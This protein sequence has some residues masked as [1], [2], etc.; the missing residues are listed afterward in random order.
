M[1][2]I[3]K[4]AIRNRKSIIRTLLS[5]GIGAL[6]AVCILVLDIHGIF[7]LICT[8]IIVAE[9]MMIVAYGK[10]WGINNIK[11]LCILY[12]VTFGVNGVINALYY[13]GVL[14]GSLLGRANT[15]TFGK[16]KIAYILPFI[17]VLSVVVVITAG[18][19]KRNI[20]MRKNIY[21]ITISVGEKKIEATALLDTGNS[22]IEPITKKPVSVIE[23]ERLKILDKEKLKYLIVPYHSVGKSHGLMTAF[24]ADKVTIDKK[25]INNA[26]I[27]IHEGKLSQS[28]QYNM[29]LHPDFIDKGDS[30]D[31]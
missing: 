22:L 20:L 4:I 5:A 2:F 3:T 17:I 18:K 31:Y 13:E 10:M 7:Q 6:Y 16:V 14:K 12:A 28:R 23:K 25:N 11:S 15:G 29:I 27:G 30:D 26:V 9:V 21:N 24:V 1:L 19:V 8:Y